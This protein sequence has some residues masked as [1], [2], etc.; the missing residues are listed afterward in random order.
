MEGVQRLPEILSGDLIVPGLEFYPV[1]V[2][3]SDPLD[4]RVHLGAKGRV[5]SLLR[6]HRARESPDPGLDD[7]EADEDHQDLKLDRKSV[8]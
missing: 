8:V 7:Q 5:S 1:C 4:E 3:Q 2:Q 6:E